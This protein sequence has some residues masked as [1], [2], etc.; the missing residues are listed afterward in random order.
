[1]KR[2][3]LFKHPTTLGDVLLTFQIKHSLRLQSKVITFPPFPLS[4]GKT[5]HCAIWLQTCPIISNKRLK[6][7]NFTQHH[8]FLRKATSKD[9]MTGSRS[10]VFIRW[11][12]LWRSVHTCPLTT[13]HAKTE[14]WI[15]GYSPEVLLCRDLLFCFHW[16]WDA[17]DSDIF[18][19]TLLDL[20]R[21][22]YRLVRA[23]HRTGTANH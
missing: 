21:F 3:H 13:E 16:G 7:W 6:R 1:M 2:T 15:Q 4:V 22:C 14:L 9:E 17:W 8:V 23:R 12:L 20:P 10:S 18:L 5:C 19:P 11:G